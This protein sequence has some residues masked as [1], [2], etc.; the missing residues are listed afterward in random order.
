MKEFSRCSFFFFLYIYA[1]QLLEC[2][3]HEN[4]FAFTRLWKPANAPFKCSTHGGTNVGNLQYYANKHSYRESVCDEVTNIMD[5]KIV[6]GELKLWS[7]YYDYFRTNHYHHH[8]VVLLARISLTLSWLFSLSFNASSR[9]SGL[10][11]VSS[12]RCCMD[13]RAGLPA[14]AR[15]YVG[16]HRSASLMSSSLLPQQY[17][18]CSSKRMALALNKP[19]RFICH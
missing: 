12:H 5:C 17:H 19:W 8:H 9:S 3:I 7:R 11:P 16:F 18:K 15:P 13:V 1:Y 2:P 4:S 6:E 14:F 10:H